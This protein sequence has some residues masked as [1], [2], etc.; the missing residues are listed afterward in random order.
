MTR[1]KKSR[2]HTLRGQLTCAG[3]PHLSNAAVLSEENKPGF[4]FDDAATTAEVWWLAEQIKANGLELTRGRSVEDL[5][6]VEDEQEEP[7]CW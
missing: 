7:S 6:E 1:K 3:I 4:E 5:V 2:R